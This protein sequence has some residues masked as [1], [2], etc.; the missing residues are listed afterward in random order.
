MPG[1]AAVVRASSPEPEPAP[2]RF[3][4]PRSRRLVRSRQFQN[5]YRHRKARRLRGDLATATWAPNGQAQ[6]RLGIAVSKRALRR[7]TDR[8][9]FKRQ[10]REH[11]RLHPLRGVD[12]IVG[13]RQGLRLPLDRQALR[14]DLAGL[15]ER[16][17]S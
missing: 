15:W 16:L 3:S 14:Q 2:G 8:N 10:V 12:L 6:A 9:A 1:A 5:V 4:F 17:P 7:S 13:A 11:F